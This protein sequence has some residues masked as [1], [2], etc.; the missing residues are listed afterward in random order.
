LKGAVLITGVAGFIGSQLAE[1]L[2]YLGY[3]VIGLDNF[4]D[5]YSPTIKRNNIR[6][7][8]NNQSFSLFQGD[9]RD[10]K[11]LGQIFLEYNIK[12]VAH[13]AARAGV[14]PSLTQPLYYQDVNIGGTINLLEISRTHNIEQ[15]VLASSSSVYGVDCPIPFHEEYK[16]N[17]TSPYAASKAA[18]EIYCYTYN[19]LYGIPIIVLRLF[20]VY[21]LRQR[22]EMAIHLFTRMI[23]SGEEIPM[24]GDG[25]SKRD[26]TYVTD[27][28]DGITQA[29]VSQNQG[30]EICNL[31]N[32]HPVTLEYL[33]YLIEKSLGKKAKIKKLPAQSGDMPI[34]FADISKAKQL[35][36]FEPKITIE[37]GIPR[38][39]KWYLESSEVL[40]NTHT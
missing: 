18:A 39:V 30:I 19:Q 17:P 34:T 7:I 27:I 10:T 4:D 40:R 11:I 38:F 2:L 37:E 31:G 1:Q 35:L 15:F 21:G 3:Q 22:P 23:N 29:L 32:S 9:I 33:I 25:T 6:S 36:N 20:T 16:M 12:M 5:Y 26:Y 28:V 24:F 13:L 14:R 8:I